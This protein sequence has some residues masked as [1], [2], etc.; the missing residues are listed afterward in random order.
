MD[1]KILQVSEEKMQ[2]LEKKLD[3]LLTTLEGVI[4]ETSEE[5]IIGPATLAYTLISTGTQV[6][7]ECAPSREDALT[8][9]MMAVQKTLE[10]TEAENG[11]EE[12]PNEDG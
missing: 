8:V 7:E 6:A 12:K 5:G 3:E 1:K 10:E 4:N 9:I 2:T 11:Q